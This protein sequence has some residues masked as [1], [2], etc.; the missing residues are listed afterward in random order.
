MSYEKDVKLFKGNFVKAMAC[1]DMAE[2][3]DPSVLEQWNW[4]T[5]CAIVHP[6]EF[7][8][9]KSNVLHDIMLAKDAS[10]W[11]GNIYNK[12]KHWEQDYG[13][14]SMLF[15]TLVR[16]ISVAKYSKKQV[17]NMRK[18][19]GSKPPAFDENYGVKQ[20]RQSKQLRIELEEWIKTTNDPHIQEIRRAFRRE[21]N[22]L[23]DK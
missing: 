19:D 16:S 20:T 1:Y 17:E 13:R 9:A 7:R 11:T 15:N 5:K 3:S 4:A 21:I 14:N 22:K 2:Y 8:D 12:M 23:K 10:E 6:S 18:K